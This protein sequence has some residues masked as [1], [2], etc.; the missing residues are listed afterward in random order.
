[1]N[2]TT[3]RPG[4]ARCALGWCLLLASCAQQDVVKDR[5]GTPGISTPLPAGPEFYAS[6]SG[7]PRADGSRTKPW[8]LQTALSQPGPV[9]PG[10]T[11]WLRGGRYTGGTYRG[12]FLSKLTGTADAPIV[13]RQ[14]PGEHAT[15]TNGLYTAGAYTWF[16]GFEITSAAAG[17][18]GTDYDYLVGAR[19]GVGNR[20]INLVIHDG[21]SSGVTSFTPLYTSA[22]Q[23]TI[24]GCLIYNNGTH[25][26]LDH[27]LYL[28]NDVATGT[29]T[30]TDNVVFNNEAF[31][32]HVYSAPANGRLSGFDIEGNVLFG[33]GSISAP[34]NRNNEILIGGTPP[35]NDVVVRNNFTYREAAS[36][37]SPYKVA[38]EIGYIDGSNANGDVVLENNDFIGGLYIN[39][40]S[41][42][43]VRGNLVYDYAGPMVLT[44]SSV[45]G[46]TW[47]DNRFYGVSTLSNWQEAPNRPADFAT[48]RAQTGLTGPGSY[49][50]SGA[51][52]NLVVVRPNQ[53]EAGR[54]NIVVYNWEQHATVSVDL[55][56]LLNAGDRYV[57]RN[58]QDF[59]GTPVA[60]GT[61][62]RGS[63]Q[64][65]MAGITP[66]APVGRAFT[67]PPVTGP[68][69]NVFVVMK[70]P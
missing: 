47:S 55:S 68:T 17:A 28:Q 11:I 24:Y 33:N 61:Y 16:W 63:I 1:L 26:N 27:G 45:S 67:P 52:P 49:A 64:L 4:R 13:V 35:A 48:W 42:G 19:S 54:A 18:S 2:E 10:S 40:W 25:F 12:G 50:G 3:W 53:Y 58:V 14:A 22:T 36:G 5:P 70:A 34:V 43:I 6:P 62:E 51:P 38:A 31:G 7:S 44:D 66:P 37:F 20:F 32:L 29:V 46:P 41:S 69:F 8:D 60:S 30:V 9:T 39:R 59:D 21:P 23:T 56:T 57:V 15:I 65:P